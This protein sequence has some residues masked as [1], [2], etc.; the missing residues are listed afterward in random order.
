MGMFS[1]SWSGTPAR[2]SEATSCRRE[3]SQASEKVRLMKPGPLTST[4]S[5]TPSTSSAA[6]ILAATSRGGIPT[7][8]ASASAALTCTSAN[9]EG[10]STGSASRCSSPSAAAIADWTLGVSATSGETMRAV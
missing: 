2:S 9:C 5:H 8:F 4:A 1:R 3:A 10:R 6:A 7:F